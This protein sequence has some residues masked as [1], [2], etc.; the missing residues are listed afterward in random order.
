MAFKKAAKKPFDLGTAPGAMSAVIT[1]WR[2]WTASGPERDMSRRV[3]SF[4]KPEGGGGGG[5]A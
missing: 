5:A 1:P 3:V 2:K 4:V